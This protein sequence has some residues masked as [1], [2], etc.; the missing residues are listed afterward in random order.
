MKHGYPKTGDTCLN[1]P[2]SRRI[3]LKQLGAATLAL[4]MTTAWAQHKF[5]RN[6][7]G[8]GVASGSP[9][10]DGVVLWTRLFDPGV[11]SSHL[12]DENLAVKWEVAT[13]PGFHQIVQSGMA[14]AV[15][16]LAHS[17]HVEVNGLPSDQWFHYRFMAGTHIS[18]T[19]KTRTFA[20]PGV[21]TPNPLRIAF[22]SCQHYEQGYFNAYPHLVKEAPDLM[23]FLG[24]YI[25]EYAPGK[26]GV[27]S[28]S[29][30]WCLTLEDYRQRYAQYKQ[31]P[32]LQAIHAACPWWLTWDD[33]EVQNDYAGT[34][35]GSVGPQSNFAKRRANAYQAYYEHMPLKAAVLMQGIA[36]LDNGAEMRIYDHV[37]YGNLL[38]LSMLDTRQYRTA[39]ACTPGGKTGSGVLDPRQCEQLNDEARSMLGLAQEQWLEQQLAG[40][41]AQTW[42]ILAQST[43]FGACSFNTSEGVKIWND[44]WDGYPAARKRLTDQ[45]TRHH[46][47]RPIILGGDVHENWVGYVKADYST[48]NS[49]VVGVEFCGTSIAS[50]DGKNTTARQRRNPHFVYSEGSRKGYAIALFSKSEMRVHLRATLD[51]RSRESAVETLASF[52]VAA[53]ASGPLR[54]ETV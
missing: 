36:G 47:P 26:Q 49:P 43:L 45:L 44:G 51:H 24:D 11:F 12:P 16:G 1:D 21:D 8:L 38:S 50:Y 7:F 23:V 30:S 37:R 53:D 40:S 3:F 13:D 17:V 22:A 31:E 29:G 34:Q 9:T 5:S 27:R 54:I 10:H 19:G 42:N 52:R 4:P 20:S 32:E 6:P 35:A 14:Q 48:P 46:V 33:H 39:Q 18:P 15:A 28:H 2:T 41:Q 25:Y